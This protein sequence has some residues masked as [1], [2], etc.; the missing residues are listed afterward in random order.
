MAAMASGSGARSGLRSAKKRMAPS[1]RVPSDPSTGNHRCL[2]PSQVKS[3]ADSPSSESEGGSALDQQSVQNGQHATFN[4]IPRGEEMPL[5]HDPALFNTNNAGAE[6]RAVPVTLWDSFHNAAG[7][8]REV[9]GESEKAVIIGKALTKAAS[10]RGT[11]RN[12]TVDDGAEPWKT[13]FGDTPVDENRI[14]VLSVLEYT[15]ACQIA[16]SGRLNVNL[17]FAVN[18]FGRG[19]V[20][21]AARDVGAKVAE[22]QSDGCPF[23]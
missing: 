5:W 8:L 12:E 22:I 21:D 6:K 10:M 17:Q 14:I 2:Q 18:V 1:C 16:S 3:W 4:S 15:F 7:G 9:Y 20:V 13:A 19:A 23:R 11:C